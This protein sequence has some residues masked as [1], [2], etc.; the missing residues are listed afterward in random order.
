MGVYICDS[1]AHLLT[2][3]NGQTSC[4]PMPL[5]HTNRQGFLDLV[6]PTDTNKVVL[7]ADFRISPHQIPI[8][9]EHPL[10]YERHG[11]ASVGAG[12]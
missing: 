6:L 1:V 2:Y 9:S 8:L 11:R 12:Y 4:A 7:F 5:G 3:L 10:P